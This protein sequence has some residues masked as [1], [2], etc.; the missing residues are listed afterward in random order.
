M[1]FYEKTYQE[2]QNSC[3]YNLFF[4]STETVGS[5][6]LTADTELALVKSRNKLVCSVDTQ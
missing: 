1:K 6:H 3:Q 4:Y 2:Q 5:E